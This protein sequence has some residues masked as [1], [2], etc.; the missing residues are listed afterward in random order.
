MVI[1][2]VQPRTIYDRAHI[3]G[4]LSFPWGAK[5]K[6]SD[7][8]Q[9]PRDKMIITYCDCGPG[10]ADSADV[11]AQLIEMGFG[12]VKVLADPSIKGWIKA[13]YPIE[14]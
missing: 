3:K 12:D 2:D 14:N 1:L 8:R 7:V 13:G 10:E 5:L 9:L 6:Q 11:A 4:A